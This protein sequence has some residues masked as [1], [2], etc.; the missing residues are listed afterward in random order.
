MAPKPDAARSDPAEDAE[1]G[2]GSVSTLGGHRGMEQPK[3]SRGSAEDVDAVDQIARGRAE[4]L[5]TVYS[6]QLQ[7]KT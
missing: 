4:A 7:S 5:G 2:V 1:Y 6:E 3:R